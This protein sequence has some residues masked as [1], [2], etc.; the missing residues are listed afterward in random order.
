MN[1]GTLSHYGWI[2]ICVL[3]LATLLAFATPFGT[4]LADGF[5]ATVASY[6]YASDGAITDVSESLGV[7]TPLDEL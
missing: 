4:F 5:S 7:I 6:F 2:V 1:R 3:V